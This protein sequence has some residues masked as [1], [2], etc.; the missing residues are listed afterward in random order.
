MS[1]VKFTIFRNIFEMFI[2][3]LQTKLFLILTGK[4]TTCPGYINV[5]EPAGGKS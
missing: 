2:C 4:M 3:V 5:N 1:N